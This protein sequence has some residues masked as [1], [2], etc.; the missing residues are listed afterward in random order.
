MPQT[1]DPYLTASQAGA[2]SGGPVLVVA[3]LLLMAWARRRMQRSDG[4]GSKRWGFGIA[5]VAL[6]V[7]SF[8][9]TAGSEIRD[10]KNND[11]VAR[12]E[13]F[14]SASGS[15]MVNTAIRQMKDNVTSLRLT[16]ISATEAGKANYDAVFDVDGR[17]Q[18]QFTEGTAGGRSSSTA[19]TPT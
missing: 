1:I 9:S 7:M 8:L 17:C 4:S 19:T 3:G 11:T 5:L 13:D 12:G 15:A 14:A 18:V 2:W 10:S 6:G 16:G